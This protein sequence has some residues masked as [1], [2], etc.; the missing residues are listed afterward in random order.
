MDQLRIIMQQ[1]RTSRWLPRL[2]A[3]A[4]GLIGVVNLASAL[5]PNIR[6]RGHLLLDIEPVE[7]IRLFHALAL[8]AGTA[9]LLVAPY[10]AK[11][12]HRAWQAALILMVALGAFDLLNALDFEETV[13]TWATPGALW[14]CPGPLRTR[15]D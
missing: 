3:A 11:R 9:L 5:S 15:H 6:W 1:L 4:A 8:P 13:I 7:T 2:A 14:W 10:L 12:R